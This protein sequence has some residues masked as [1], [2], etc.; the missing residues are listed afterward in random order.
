MEEVELPEQV[1]IIVSEW[2]GFYLL[3]ESMLD[4]VLY[5]RDQWLKPGGLLLP[6]HAAI[7]A[8][9]VTLDHSLWKEVSFWDNVYG[10]SMAILS[11]IAQEK[12]LVIIEKKRLI[13]YFSFFFF[14]PIVETKT[15]PPYFIY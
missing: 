10:F 15:R 8:S 2:M 6:T 1:D 13:T 3:H 9:L 7:Y 11:E 4:S 5:A 14:S 12:V